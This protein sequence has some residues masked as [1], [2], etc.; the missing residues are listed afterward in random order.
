MSKFEDRLLQSL[1]ADDEAFLQDLEQDIGLFQQM[2]AAFSGPLKYWTVFAFVFSFLIFMVCLWAGYNM[3][4]S[5][6]LKEVVLWGALF[7]WTSLAVGL[8][9][10]WFWLRMNHLNVLR[11]LKRIELRLVRNE[12]A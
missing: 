12:D 1:S 6:D 5:E 9:K 8:I 7:G 11:E 10:I 3:L 4:Q 2:G